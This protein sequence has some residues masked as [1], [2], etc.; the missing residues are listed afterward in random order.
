MYLWGVIRDRLILFSVFMLAAMTA[1]GARFSQQDS[2]MLA[3]VFSYKRN[4]TVGVNGF[5]SNVYV[6]HLYQTPR[7]NLSLWVIPSTYAIAR[8]QRSFVSEQYSRLNFRSVD[9]FDNRRQVYYTTIPHNRRTMP[10]LFEFITPNLYDVT[11]Y[12]DHILSPFFR[13]NQRYYS[14]S[15]ADLGHGHMRLYFRPRYM[16]NTQL[17]KGRAIVEKATGKIEQVEMEGEYDMIR[18]QTLSM[19]GDYGSR[20]LLPKWCK[21]SIVFNFLGNK[22]TSD[23]TAVF[24][25]PVTLPDSVDVNGDRA[26][27]DSV[28]PISLTR[29]EQAVYHE[30]D[31]I[32]GVLPADSLLTAADSL[33]ADSMANDATL[34]AELYKRTETTVQ[35]D[36]D[37]KQDDDTPRQT[38]GFEQLKDI[39]WEIGKRM[40]FSNGTESENGYIK[41]SPLLSPQFISYSKSSGLSWKFRLRG[42][43]RFSP[44]YRLQFSPNAAWK[45]TK[46]EFYYDVPLFFFYNPKRESFL[47]FTLSKGNEIANNSMLEQLQQKMGPSPDLE[48]QELHLYGDLMLHLSN[49][50]RI[51]KSL[52]MAVGLTYHYRLGKYS[53]A[54]R[55]LGLTDKFSSLAPALTIKLRPWAKA[56]VFSI[57][58]ER[59]LNIEPFNIDYERWETDASIKH[60]MTRLQTLNVRFGGGLYTRKKGNNFMDFANFRANNLPEG[61]DDDWSGDFQLLDSRLYNESNYY[62]RGNLSYES[63]LLAA[64]FIPLVGRYVERERAY[65]SS[66]SIAHTRLYSELGYGFTCRYFSMGLFASFLNTQYQQMTAKFTF[67]LFRRW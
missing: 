67:E 57:N 19:Q 59:A 4:Y 22:V 50:M 45:I 43:Y 65:V 61:W 36:D 37:D 16:P 6:K 29:E 30:R 52:S 54:L 34:I 2:L 62:L 53:H 14:Y 13:D 32:D 44:R 15:T 9:D 41:L 63:P 46:K 10:V 42:E 27:I 5:Q 56:P 11:I 47:F 26:L 49:S 35:Q 1:M 60:Y 55:Q 39:G 8:G 51:S 17:V 7:R 23:F 48:A 64:S 12:G 3:K 20:S 40:I 21:T 38:N 58:Y 66:I 24:D 31:S 33:A 18:F 28:R 25:C